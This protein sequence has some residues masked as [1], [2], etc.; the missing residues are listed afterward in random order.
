MKL[1]RGSKSLRSADGDDINPLSGHGPVSVCVFSDQVK[2]SASIASAPLAQ[3][4][5][6]SVD[7]LFVYLFVRRC[8]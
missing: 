1:S 2:A 8:V 7:G 3:G 4:E 5:E 6:F